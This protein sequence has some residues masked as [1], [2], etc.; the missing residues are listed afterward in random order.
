MKNPANG[1]TLP[2]PEP[3]ERHPLSPEEASLLLAAID[4]YFKPLIYIALTTGLRWSELAGL[5]LEDLDLDGPEPHLTVNRGLH[6]SSIGPTYEKPK[7]TAGHRTLPLAP[8]Q[9]AIIQAHLAVSGEYRT[10]QKTD[11]VFMTKKG[12]RLEYQNF[13]RR[14]FNPAARAAGLTRTRIHDL[15][16]TTATVLVA[17]SQDLKTIQTVMGHSDIRLTLGVYA[18][19]TDERSRTAINSLVSKLCSASFLTN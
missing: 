18:L 14:F 6:V 15:R 10:G 11:P 17:S 12:R 7:S 3:V 16:R 9:V 4:P 13:V 1:V 2:K 19:T 5:Q 8:A